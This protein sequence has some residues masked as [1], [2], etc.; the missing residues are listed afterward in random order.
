M[1]SHGQRFRRRAVRRGYKVDEVDVF[2]DRVEATL[3]GAPTGPEVRSHEVRDVVFRVRFGGYDEWQVDLHLDRVE[4]QLAEIEERVSSSPGRGAELRATMNPA[5]PPPPPPQPV[6]TPGGPPGPM[7]APPPLP[8]RTPNANVPT[9]AMPRFDQRFEE[10]QPQF[11][12]PPPGP[13]NGFDGF[14]GG[15][16]R[17]DMT[18]E[19]RMERPQ[20]PRM[21]EPPRNEPP[22]IDPYGPSAGF[23]SQTGQQPVYGGGLP[24]RGGFDNEATG[25]F[26]AP[27][28]GFDNDAT[29]TFNAPRGGYDNEA[30]GT[31]SAPRG[32]FD[33]DATGTFNAPRGGYDSD[34]TGTFGAVPP[35]PAVSSY[36]GGGFTT[37]PPP[38]PPAPAG[39]A[40]TGELQR[41][42]QL[43]RTFQLRRF[44]SGYDPQQVD[45]L[46]ESLLGSLS[47]RSGGPVS[48]GELDPSRLS[49]VPGG[50][51][52]A[53]VEQALREIREI[54][55][56]R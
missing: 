29:G 47:G 53:E 54:V 48:D 23:S 38:P 21:P 52:E 20:P 2:L 30:T 33:N 6:A 18:S 56:R 49:L 15:H 3:N 13:Q 7:N 44:G 17:P 51:Y 24:Q 40:Y 22:R 1:S 8:T 42:D 31:F 45:R 27:R 12:G 10:P 55:G 14:N 11:A 35:A 32:G 19:I 26:S 9:G 25:T 34:A 36:G 4:R 5:P 39:P 50:Y 16:G 46:F 28:G 37:P 41:V 43:R